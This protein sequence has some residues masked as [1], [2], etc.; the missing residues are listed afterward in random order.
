MERLEVNTVLSPWTPSCL[1]CSRTCVCETEIK[2]ELKRQ[3][4]RRKKRK[5]RKNHAAAD[6]TDVSEQGI[7]RWQKYLAFTGHGPSTDMRAT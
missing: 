6:N 1:R 4:M 2:S 7:Q 3:R 5:K